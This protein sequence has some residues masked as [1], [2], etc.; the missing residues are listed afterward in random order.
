MNL[1]LALTVT[2]FMFFSTKMDSLLGLDPTLLVGKYWT[3]I[4]ANF[5][6]VYLVSVAVCVIVVIL[7]VGLTSK[8]GDVGP[9]P[10]VERLGNDSSLGCYSC[11]LI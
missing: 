11:E 4:Y 5:S 9:G 10:S 2:T 1:T 8:R 7:T 6:D 3:S